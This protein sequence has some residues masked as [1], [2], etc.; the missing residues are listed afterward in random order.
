MSTQTVRYYYLLYFSGR[1]LCLETLWQFHIFTF[2]FKPNA[3]QLWKYG[4]E[5]VLIQNV[6]L[7]QFVYSWS[8]K[9]WDIWKI[10]KSRHIY[11]N[12]SFASGYKYPHETHCE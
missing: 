11:V 5:K 7:I 12:G 10:G 2:F 8:D 4:N 1:S 6:F 9:N 3:D